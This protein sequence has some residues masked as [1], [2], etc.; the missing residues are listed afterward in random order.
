[1]KYTGINRLFRAE[2]L[3]RVLDK[4]ADGTFS[5]F[6]DDWKWILAYSRGTIPDFV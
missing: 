2:S 3:Q 5:E 1:M 6:F 4:R